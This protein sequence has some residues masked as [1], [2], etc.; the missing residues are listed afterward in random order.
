[1]YLVG[2]RSFRLNCAGSDMFAVIIPFYQREPGI[3][4]R[5]LQS[6]A[7][8]DVADQVVVYVVDDESPVAPEP[9]VDSVQWGENFQVRIL[10]KPNGGPASARNY[11]LDRLKDEQY[12]AFLD[13]DDT[14]NDYHLSAAKF[15][16]D[17]GFDFYTADWIIDEQGTRSHDQYYGNSMALA[18]HAQADWAYE[19]RDDLINYTVRGPIGSSCSMVVTRD[20]LGDTRFDPTLRTSGEDGLFAT[21]LAS[22]EPKVM[23]S[24]RVDTVLGK[25]I[26]IFSADGW[27]SRNGVMRSIYFLR[28]RILMRPLVKKYP[29][30]EKKLKEKIRNARREFW[31]VALAAARKGNLPLMESWRLLLFDIYLIFY[32]P[33]AIYSVVQTKIS[34]RK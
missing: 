24:K 26:N 19:L 16:F 3:L 27:D 31:R 29:C 18:P 30:A 33:A 17:Q 32:A 15:A 34:S 10:K 6:V 21:T 28:S 2:I 25:G 11:A 20:L 12:V 4:A 22:K 14:W 13:S 9:E 8:Q 23:I 5:T 1:M 7:R